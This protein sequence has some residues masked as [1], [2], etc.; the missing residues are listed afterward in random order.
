MNKWIDGIV[1]NWEFSGAGRMQIQRF[2]ISGNGG[3]VRIVGMSYDEAQELFKKALFETNPVTGV[4]TV[5]NMPEEVRINTQRAF[6]TDPRQP[7][8]YAPG[9][10]PTGRYF[11]PAV[12]PDCFGLTPGDCAPDLYFDTPWYSEWDMKF[13]KRFPFGR[14]AS[15]DF[16]VE[17]FNAFNNSNFTRNYTPNANT[18][19]FQI[20]AQQSGARIGQLVWRVNF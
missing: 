15:V 3:N 7:T 11:A 10:E 20:T 4:M 9:T 2:R 6:S 12:G 17:I 1:G 5:Y 16:S 18:N 19:V 13:V 8:Y 14:K